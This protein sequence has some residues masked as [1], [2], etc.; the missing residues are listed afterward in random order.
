MPKWI[1][2]FRKEYIFL[3]NF[4]PASVEY[5][6]QIYRTVEHAYQA[7]KTVNP[8]LRDG[9]RLSTSPATASK[10]GRYLT[11]REGWNE[12][13]LGVMEFLLRQKFAA[14]PLRQKLLDTGDME[15][16]EGNNWGDYFWGQVN[17]VGDNNLGIL[18]MKIRKELQ[19]ARQ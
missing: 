2:S 16:I 10:L 12:M 17:G 14:D 3:S 9:I 15:L 11:L 6:G 8:R 13:R 19:D 4:Y 7:A 1:T 18:L 5:E